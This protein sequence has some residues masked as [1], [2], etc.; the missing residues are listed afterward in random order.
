MLRRKIEK[1]I[2]PYC[3]QHKIGV[4]AYSPMQA[5]LLTGKFD[6]NKLAPDDWRRKNPYFQ[7][8]FLSKAIKFTDNVRPIADK[9]KKTIGQIA[10]AWV[11]QNPAITSAIVGARTVEQ[12]EGNVG[13]AGF[14]LRDEDIQFIQNELQTF[15]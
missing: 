6:F 14:T 4:V 7:E 1:E 15:A 13:A 10:V 12:V 3:L 11:L 9:Y 2:L 5:G 8:P